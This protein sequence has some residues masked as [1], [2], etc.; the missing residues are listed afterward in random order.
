MIL[1]NID[2]ENIE[3]QFAETNFGILE[4]DVDASGKFK[5]LKS[6]L[7]KYND[8]ITELESEFIK[9]CKRDEN[10]KAMVPAKYFLECLLVW[11]SKR[12]YLSVF[13]NFVIFISQTFMGLAVLY[14]IFLHVKNIQDFAKVS[15]T[16]STTFTVSDHC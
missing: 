11:P 6:R 8:S 4:K 2:D 12:T 7:N 5:K 1:E 3:F 10:K 9:D 14:Y 13:L 15:I 16:T